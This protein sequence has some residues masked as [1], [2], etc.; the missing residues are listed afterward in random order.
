MKWVLIYFVLL[1]GLAH[2]ASCSTPEKTLNWITPDRLGAGVSQGTMSAHGTSNKFLNNQPVPMEMD[3]DG[4]T[5]GTSI[6]LEWDFPQWEEKPDYDEYLR[7]RVRTLHLE[8]LLLQKEQ[9][10]KEIE[11]SDNDIS[12][13]EYYRE[14]GQDRMWPFKLTQQYL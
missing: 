9:E 5:Y 14:L 2:L 12:C 11:Q 6:W 7:E 4:E 1:F 10:I 13:L 8:K 3:I